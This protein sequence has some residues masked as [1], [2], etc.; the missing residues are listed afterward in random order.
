MEKEG[1]GEKERKRERRETGR[2]KE[3]EREISAYLDL[4]MSIYS[5]WTY[6]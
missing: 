1:G 5:K 6:F 4:L 3:R 2:A